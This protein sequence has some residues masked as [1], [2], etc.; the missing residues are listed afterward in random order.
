MVL[1]GNKMNIKNLAIIL[2][3]IIF[4]ALPAK[5]EIIL[6]LYPKIT[7]KHDKIA[8]YDICKISG[9]NKN[10]QSLLSEINICSVPEIGHTKSITKRDILRRL[11][12]NRFGISDIKFAGAQTVSLEK[13]HQIVTKDM[14][15]EKL[16]DHLLKI[17]GEQNLNITIEAIKIRS[18]DKL[19]LSLGDLEITFKPALDKLSSSM[20][21]YIICLVNG[22]RE[23][24]IWANI[25]MSLKKEVL[26]AKNTIKKYQ[27]IQDGDLEAKIIKLNHSDYNSF[28]SDKNQILGKRSKINIKNGTI[29]NLKMIEPIPAVKKGERI[30]IVIEN[31]KLRIVSI[32]ETKEDGFL[33]KGIRVMNISSKKEISGIL[34]DKDTVLINY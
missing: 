14:L 22:R 6:D 1:K 15:A 29:L 8:L 4:I 5:A 20:G 30:N 21:I 27:A 24:N 3:L 26:V 33:E 9:A 7:T 31:E 25:K 34:K 10:E 12:Q 32:G 19:L 17:A 11:K 13:A 23:Q 18:L 16:K 2:I 28:F